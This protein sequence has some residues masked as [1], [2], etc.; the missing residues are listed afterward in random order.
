MLKLRAC[1]AE[2]CTFRDVFERFEK[3]GAKVRYAG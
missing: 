1:M 2:A 3:A